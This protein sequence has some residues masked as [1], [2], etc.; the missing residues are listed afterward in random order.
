MKTEE[1]GN[2]TVSGIASGLLFALGINEAD[3]VV[4]VFDYYPV[5]V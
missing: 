4:D 2:S 5:R 1:L 3:E